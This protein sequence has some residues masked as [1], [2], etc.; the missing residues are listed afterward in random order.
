MP[1]RG[2]AAM[3]FLMT[4]GWAILAVLI[5][6]AALAYF[7]VL[8]SA[9]FLPESCTLF[10]GIACTDVTV[11]NVGVSLVVQNGL[12]QNLNPFTISIPGCTAASASNGLLDGEKE[13]I[14]L[15]CDP[16][17][18]T[19]SKFKSDID[20][21]YSQPAGIEHTRKGS[22]FTQVEND[23][24]LNGGL[25]YGVYDANYWGFY[26]NPLSAGTGSI[27]STT[28]HTGS[29]SFKVDAIIPAGESPFIYQ[30]FSSYLP[31]GKYI[32]TFWAKAGS[33]PTTMRSVFCD[34]SD[35]FFC[36]TTHTIGLDWAPYSN[37][38]TTTLPLTSIYFPFGT[39]AATY[40]IDDVK[41]TKS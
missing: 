13:I 11:N 25:E 14:I 7:G 21:D 32:I 4:Y 1:K 37:T 35:C 5:T 12:G 6:I 18:T 40:W 27:D 2:H 9:R 17:L 10:P 8:N 30:Y 19:N 33:T 22:I 26:A 29:N 15:R 24:V 38:C 16:L 23:Y 3:E 28:P 36:S 31:V 20:I 41:L 34:T 39:A